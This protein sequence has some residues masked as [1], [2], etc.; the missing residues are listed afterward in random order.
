MQI[1]MPFAGDAQFARLHAAA[2]LILPLLPALAASSPIVD[3]KDTGIMDYRLEAYRTNARRIPS[4]AGMVIPET[5][6]DRADYEQRILEP[7]YRDIAPHDPEGVLCHEWLNSRGAI[8]RFD[9]NAI[10][11][12]VAD[13]Q[14]CPRADLAI[15]AASAAVTEALYSERWSTLWQQQAVG[16]AAL[17]RVLLHTIRRAEDAL[18]DDAQFLDVLGIKARRVRAGEIWQRLLEEATDRAE[19]AAWWRASIAF[20]LERGSLARRIVRAL[21]GDLARD[22]VREVYGRLCR[23]LE[24]GQMFE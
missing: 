12:R 5:V 22:R 20:I 6:V 9:R 17:Q 1:N 14:E 3:G 13:A 4:I 11:I 8:A 7:M 23:C 18:V 2:R 15:A 19:T 21:D 10:E 16:T 24:A